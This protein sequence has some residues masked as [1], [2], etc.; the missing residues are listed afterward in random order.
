MTF[1]HERLAADPHHRASVHRRDEAWL[2]AHW[3]DPDARALVIGGSRIRPVDGR[4]DWRP[5][6]EVPDGTRVLLGEHDGRTWWSVL[7]EP[8][9]DEDGWVDLRALLRHLLG[10]GVREA[11]LLFHAI[12]MAEWHRATRFCSR[13]AGALEAG[14]AGHELVC[15]GCGRATFPRTDPAVIMN[16][17]HGEPG[18]EGEAILL[19]RRAQWPDGQF[20]TLA[21]FCEPGESLE[22]AVRREVLEEVGIAVGEVRYFG[23]QGWPFPASLML[24]FTAYAL[25]REPVV[26]E[27]E[28]EIAEARWFTR[29]ELLAGASDGSLRLP[30]GVSIS[31]SLVEAWYGGALPGSW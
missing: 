4:P 23:N 19:G 8:R 22:D 5:T 27:V 1:P 6:S 20:S 28:D 24:G 15:T 31:R 21:G 11:P 12:G 14:A 25:D 16:V 3:R 13:C 2:D 26:D 9:R 18:A 30:G 7:V 17:V 10:E 29:A